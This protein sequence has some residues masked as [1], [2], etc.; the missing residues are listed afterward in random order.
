MRPVLFSWRPRHAVRY[1]ALSTMLSVVFTP[2]WFQNDAMVV[3]SLSTIGMEAVELYELRVTV[4][5]EA[6][7]AANICLAL[8]G[9]Y[10]K[11]LTVS[12]KPNMTDGIGLGAVWAKPPYRDLPMPSRSIAMSSALRTFRSFNGEASGYRLSMAMT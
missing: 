12:S 2:I 11:G 7:A 6:P 1:V 5:L 8:F 3:A 9:S 4:G 10:G